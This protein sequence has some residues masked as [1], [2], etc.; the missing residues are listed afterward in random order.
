MPVQASQHGLT[1]ST[2]GFFVGQ[3][4]RPGQSVDH[5][6]HLRVRRLRLLFGRHLAEVELIENSLPDLQSLMICQILIEIIKAD[7][8]FLFF[9]TMTLKTVLFKEGLQLGQ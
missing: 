4:K 8:T 2:A 5:R 7:I 1:S 9:G 6:S 3:R